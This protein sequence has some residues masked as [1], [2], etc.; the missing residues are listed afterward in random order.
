MKINGIEIPDELLVE[1]G[2]TPCEK[3]KPLQFNGAPVWAYVSDDPDGYEDAVID[4]RKL[5][6]VAGDCNGLRAIRRGKSNTESTDAC[7]WRY[8]WEIPEDEA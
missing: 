7:Y 5:H 8:A 1:A 4:K 2:W 3:P 6:V